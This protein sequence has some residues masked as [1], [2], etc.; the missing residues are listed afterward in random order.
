MSPYVTQLCAA[1]NVRFCFLPENSTHLLQPLDVAV[2]GPMK[3]YWREILREWKEDCARKNISYSSLPKQEF[4]K[5]L[6]KLMEKD[7]SN[8]IGGGFE[9]T[10]IFP[11][12][13]D[14][15]LAKLPQENRENVVSDVHKQL[16]KKL[17][18]MR[19]SPAATTSAQRPKKKDKLPPGASYTCAPGGPI[20]A[21]AVDA[22]DVD[23]PSVQVAG[24]S[25]RMLCF[26]DSASE[27]LENSGSSS[28]SEDSSSS[29]PE[30]A[31]MV[32]S[33]IARLGR[34]RP[35][36]EA[37]EQERG[38]C[39]ETSTDSEEDDDQ[40]NS[41]Q[42]E[43]DRQENEKQDKEQDNEQDNKQVEVVAEYPPGC[44]VVAVYEEDWYVGQVMEK[45]G[46]PEAEEREEY[47]FINFM[48]R[49]AGEKLQWPR[50]LDHLNVLKVDI[51]FSCQPPTPS[52]GTSSSRSITYSL[53][54][55]EL[56][57]AKRLFMLNKAYYPTSILPLM[58]I[59]GSVCC[60][61]WY[62]SV[63]TCKQ[64]CVQYRYLRWGHFGGA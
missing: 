12:N 31:R 39:T 41:K 14:R 48:M 30:R 2:F 3:R 25:R 47:L 23:D 50:R 24:P 21:P 49:T 36:Q 13:P 44:Y 27:L 60:S 32:K 16:L 42:G 56:K 40:Q 29:E 45:E 55:E 17:S 54:K 53:S 46:E 22:D 4:P 57:K 52:P 62:L 63:T 35:L 18:G 15:V 11:F 59:F 9:A 26:G 43:N 64:L 28:D 37:D 7:Y 6:N 20:V 10:G 58:V 8:A 5:L 38:T 61:C 33:I 1:N 34:K 51:L 19:Y